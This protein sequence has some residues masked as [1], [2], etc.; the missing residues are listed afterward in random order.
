VLAGIKKTKKKDAAGGGKGK[1]SGGKK[2]AGFEG[3]H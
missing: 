1:G 2:R 3:K